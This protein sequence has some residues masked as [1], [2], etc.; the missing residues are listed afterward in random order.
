M[1]MH[2]SDLQKEMD[3]QYE[4]M[5]IRETRRVKEEIKTIERQNKKR[6]RELIILC[7]LIVVWCACNSALGLHIMRDGKLIVIMWWL[8]MIC[9]PSIIELFSRRNKRDR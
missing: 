4:L 8:Q 2:K 3:R 5:A 7:L 6:I 9:L 1:N